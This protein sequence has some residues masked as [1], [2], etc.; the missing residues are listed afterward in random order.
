MR[1]KGFSL[2][3]FVIA[4]GIG[5]IVLL[6][7]S[8][9]LVRGTN[10]FRSGND[11]VNMRNDYQI[12][13][14]QIDEA[15]MEAKMLIIEKQGED[16]V[17]YTGEVDPG[18][19]DFKTA[20]TARTTEKVIIYDKSEESIY[21]LAEYE[22]PVAEGAGTEKKWPEGNRIC[23][24]VKNFSVELDVS[25]QRTE[26]NDVGDDV[27]YY[28]NPVR[29]NIALAL[30]NKNSDVAS[31]FSVNMRNRLKGIAIYTTS[32][33]GVLLSS[34]TKVEYNVK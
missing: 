3:E 23:N 14:N 31:T 9:M 16:I 1:D 25:S 13:R 10:L 7:V 27:I 24:I 12:V 8:V 26:K 29:V 22:E 19:R 20:A 32:N 2:I 34:G 6:M 15:I 4:M 30:E 5:S 11:D 21:I 28:A 18:S 17:I 33:S